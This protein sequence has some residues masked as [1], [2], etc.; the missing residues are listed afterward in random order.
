MSRARTSATTPPPPA[1]GAQ[2]VR[3][4]L[5]RRASTDESNQPYSLDAQASRLQLYVAS[6]PG[7]VVAGDYVERASGKDVTGRAELKRLLADADRGRFDLVLVARIDRWSRNLVDLLDTVE[8]LAAAGVGFHSAT[9]HFDTSSPMGKMTL[10]MLGMFAEFERS[11]II[12]RIVR[13][14]AAKI[15]RGIPLS[16]RVGYGLTLDE[17]GRI[18]ADPETIGVVRRIFTAYVTTQQGTKAIARALDHDGLPG[19]GGRNWTADSVSRVLRNR[20][21]LGEL[22]HRDSWH[23]GA[24]DAVIDPGLFAEAQRVADSRTGQAAASRRRGDYLL[25][26]TVTCGRCG[27]AYVGTAGTSAGGRVVRYYSCG[28]SRRHGP[29]RCT[30]PSLSADDLEALV[31]DALLDVY[32]NTDLFAQAIDA[33]LSAHADTV[34]DLTEELTAAR[35]AIASKERVRRRYQDDYEAGHLTA[36]RYEDRARQLDDELAA[37]HARV[38]DLEVAAQAPVVPRMPTASELQEMHAHLATGIRSGDVAVRKALFTALVERIEV[39]DRDDIRPVFRLYD[40]AAR[41][42][43]QAAAAER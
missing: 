16:S 31:T 3:V 22:W 10:Q 24:H 36:A 38:A 12:D 4:A 35:A 17:D 8:A 29:A 28:T 13:G 34:A 6:H 14:N 27:G 5:Y 37:L 41:T 18:T 42:I 11:L 15:A 2:T 39:H 20:A 1:P 40:P 19:P 26:G 21:F 30:G 25:T 9:E 33:H 23:A 43:L 7:W 32:T